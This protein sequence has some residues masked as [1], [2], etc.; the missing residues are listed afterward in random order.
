M[1]KQSLHSRAAV[2]PSSIAASVETIA[3]RRGCL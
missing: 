2:V 1:Q 3:G